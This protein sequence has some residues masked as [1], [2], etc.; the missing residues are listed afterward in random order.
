M[1]IRENVFDLGKQT[2][3]SVSKGVIRFLKSSSKRDRSINSDENS[4]SDNGWKDDNQSDTNNPLENFEKIQKAS[5]KYSFVVDW[6][7]PENFE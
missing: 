5:L 3:D 6:Q 4:F 1:K 2:E 7:M